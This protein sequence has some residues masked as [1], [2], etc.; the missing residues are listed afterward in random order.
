MPSVAP[1][2]AFKNMPGFSRLNPPPHIFFSLTDP[3][4]HPDDRFLMVNFTTDPDMGCPTL[5]IQANEYVALTVPS[6]LAFRM[7]RTPKMADIDGAITSGLMT[8]NPPLP[9]PLVV[10]ICAG[11]HGSRDAID[12]IKA[13]LRTYG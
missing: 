3:A 8:T 2:F 13:F 10:K 1:G 4:K 9:L 11:L 12:S 6:M 5:T 7:A